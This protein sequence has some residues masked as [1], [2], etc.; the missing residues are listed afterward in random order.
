MVDYTEGE[1][2]DRNQQD[3]ALAMIAGAALGGNVAKNKKR[4]VWSLV[5]SNRLATTETVSIRYNSVVVAVI[6]VTP[7]GIPGAAVAAGYNPPVVMGGKI[8]EP[9]FTF[10]GVIAGNKGIEVVG[11]ADSSIDVSAS[12]YDIP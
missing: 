3:K 8:K 4:C 6:Q 7:G 10:D 12:F 11:S 9:I 5:F 2:R 1:L